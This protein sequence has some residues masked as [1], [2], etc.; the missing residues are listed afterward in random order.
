MMLLLSLN[1]I[2]LS[3]QK[4]RTASI[5]KNAEDENNSSFNE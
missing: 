3:Y 4:K 2:N 1:S 5:K